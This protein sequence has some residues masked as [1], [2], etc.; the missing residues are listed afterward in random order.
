MCVTLL[1]SSRDPILNHVFDLSFASQV[2]EYPMGDYESFLSER[3]STFPRRVNM[4]GYLRSYIY[5][6][7]FY[8]LSVARATQM[9]EAHCHP[10]EPPKVRLTRIREE[11]L[12]GASKLPV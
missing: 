5:S 3:G 11:R 4:E 6:P 10:E 7:A 8:L 12:L 1:D 9:V 2:R